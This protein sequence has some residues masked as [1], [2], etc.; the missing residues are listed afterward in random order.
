MT[1]LEEVE[2][3]F[4]ED[5]VEITNNRAINAEYAVELMKLEVLHQISKSLAII[6]DMIR[7]EKESD[8]DVPEE[9]QTKEH[10]EREGDTNSYRPQRYVQADACRSIL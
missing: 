4:K 8:D 3:D 9:L 7:E 6:V 1:R 2:K 10:S 5:T